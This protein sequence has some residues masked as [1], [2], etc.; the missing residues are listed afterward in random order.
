MADIFLSYSSEDFERV[1]ALAASLETSGLTVWWDRN[2]PGG[3]RYS[4]VIE[5]EIAAAKKV[6]VV[7]TTNSVKSQWVADEADIG[8]NQ[9]KLIPVMLDDVTQP[10]G[11]RQIQSIDF[12]HWSGQSTDT[13][14]TQLLASIRDLAPPGTAPGTPEAV[15]LVKRPA[16]V[17]TASV[18][19]VILM[20]LAALQFLPFTTLSKSDNQESQATSLAE[21]NF[22][23]RSTIAVLPF[24]NLS[25]D[26][27]QEYFSDGITEDL[28]VSLH[29][30]RTFP[31]IAR[32]STF[33]YKGTTQNIPTISAELGADYLITGSVR[34]SDDQVRISVQLHD[35]KGHTLWANRYDIQWTDTYAVQDEIVA[36][37]VSEIAPKLLVEET[38]IS[39]H[40]RPEDMKAWDYYLRARSLTTASIGFMDING[41]AV[42]LEN[43]ERARELLTKAIDLEPDFAAA[44]ALMMHVDGAY[45]GQLGA[46]VSQEFIDAAIVRSLESAKI[47]RRLNPFDAYACSC[48]ALT[49]QLIGR[50]EEALTIQEEAL[51]ELPT[52]SVIHAAMGKILESNGRFDR[53][54]KEM[55]TAKRLSPRDIE[56]STYLSFE[57][58]IYLGLGRFEDAVTTSAKAIMLSPDLID[59][60]GLGIIARFALGDIDGARLA[61]EQLQSLVPDFKPRGMWGGPLHPAVVNSLPKSIRPSHPGATI[62][63]GFR[64]VLI[65]LGWDGGSS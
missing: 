4:E 31:I 3:V 50:S 61:M 58:S 28:I 2:L 56:M 29:S 12:S 35:A 45:T 39:R 60:H 14:F 15:P 46:Y 40:K 53:A 55:A 8:R 54:L 64:A 16:F 41:G 1:K 5:D 9:N 44:H 34:R 24:A 59:A 18:A 30:Y 63:D 26:P 27:E 36:S 37:V 49:L 42:T 22:D 25:G 32:T 19:I 51:R 65:E 33:S 57:A 7:W 21:R 52:N 13:P 62:R 17:A 11:F 47:A 43:N 20:A 6:L 10:L 23:G 38:D 48:Q